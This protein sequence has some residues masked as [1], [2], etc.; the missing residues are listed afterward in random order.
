MDSKR[1]IE[2][3]ALGEL[4]PSAC[5]PLAILLAFDHSRIAGEKSVSPQGGVVGRIDLGQGSCK[6][7]GARACL[8]IDAAADDG[9]NYV[10]FILARSNHQRL[11]SQGEEFWNFK[12]L[13]C[14]HIVDGELAGSFAKEN[15]GN[16]ALAPTGSNS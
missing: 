15:P 5:S 4:E 6:T 16:R 9:N 1:T 7:V 12:I 14:I 8:A 13:G 10:E 2:K 11:A 3:S